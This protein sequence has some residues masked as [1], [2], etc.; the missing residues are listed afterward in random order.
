MN[1]GLVGLHYETIDEVDWVD[2]LMKSRTVIYDYIAL[3]LMNM[4]LCT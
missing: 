1:D 3:T 2:T 4:T